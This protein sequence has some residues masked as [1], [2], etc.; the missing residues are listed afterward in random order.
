MRESN[1]TKSGVKADWGIRGTKLAGNKR[2]FLVTDQ[3]NPPGGTNRAPA[4][5]VYGV[6]TCLSVNFRADRQDLLTYG[7]NINT[8]FVDRPKHKFDPSTYWNVSFDS[9]RQPQR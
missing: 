3:D 6:R 5:T 2:I 8:Y 7:I 4:R 1:R 9:E